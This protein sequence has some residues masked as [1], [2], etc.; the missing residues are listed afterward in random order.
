MQPHCLKRTFKNP[1]L[2]SASGTKRSL[3]LQKK[4]Q[5]IGVPSSRDSTRLVDGKRQCLRVSTGFSQISDEQGLDGG[6]SFY[7]LF[8]GMKWVFIFPTLRS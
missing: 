2:T 3:K 4:R 1:S 6:E 7:P 8:G 5:I